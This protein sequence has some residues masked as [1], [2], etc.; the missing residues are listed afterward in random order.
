MS[1][2]K[3]KPVEACSVRCSNLSNTA[4]FQKPQVD[5][6]G[7]IHT[8]SHESGFSRLIECFDRRIFD[9]NMQMRL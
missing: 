5:N 4:F 8:G 9:D 2:K 7:P 6:V 3:E 1:L